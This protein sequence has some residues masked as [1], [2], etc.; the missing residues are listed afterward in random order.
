[1][2]NEGLIDQ[3]APGVRALKESKAD[4]SKDTVRKYQIVVL[5]QGTRNAAF[6]RRAATRSASSSDAS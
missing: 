2:C 6:R 5:T 3:N 1:M 4:A